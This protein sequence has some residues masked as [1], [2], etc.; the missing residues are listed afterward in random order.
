MENKYQVVKYSKYDEL[1]ILCGDLTQEEAFSYVTSIKMAGL[2][3]DWLVG[4]LDQP[5]EE[6]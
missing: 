6:A 1:N 2:S 3:D 5:L 4:I